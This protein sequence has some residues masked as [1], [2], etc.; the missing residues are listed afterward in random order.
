MT[1][2][3]CLVYHHIPYLISVCIYHILIHTLLVVL[4][5]LDPSSS[6][7]GAQRIVL[8]RGD[9]LCVPRG[10]IYVSRAAR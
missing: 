4:S 1:H 7:G 8:R 6:E 2:H 5:L 10:N 9:T 3:T